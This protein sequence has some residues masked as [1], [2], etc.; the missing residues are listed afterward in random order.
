V[1]SK[2]AY[3]LPNIDK[4]GFLDA[5]S[6]HNQIRMDT[7]NEEKTTL[8]TKDTNFCYRVMPFGLKNASAIY[9]RLMDQVFKQ[10][11]RRNVEVYV[12]DM[13]IKSQ[14]I[15]QHVANLEKVFGGTLQI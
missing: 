11:I 13:V 3:P 15:A 2:D 6:G 9:Q 5:Y 14:S 8:I 10:Q 4:L 1:C 7:P 12:D